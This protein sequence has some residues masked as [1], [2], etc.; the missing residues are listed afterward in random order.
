MSAE[1]DPKAK[2]PDVLFVHSPSEAG[3]G[4]NVVR[5]REDSVE[6]GQ[7]RGVPEGKPIHGEVVKL[8]PRSEHKQLF[9]VNVVVPGPAPGPKA[10]PEAQGRSGPPQVATEAYRENW[11]A[12]FGARRRSE[13]EE[14]N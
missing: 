14:P 4:F 13:G 8:T 1:E 6:V 12:I 10:L 9:D 11:T 2:A 3:D 5:M 7:I